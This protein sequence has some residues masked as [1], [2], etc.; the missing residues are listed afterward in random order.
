MIMTDK[1]A[2]QCCKDSSQNLREFMKDNGLSIRKLAKLTGLAPNTIKKFRKDCSGSHFKTFW[3]IGGGM[4]EHPGIMLTI[5]LRD[6][7]QFQS[8]HQ[9]PCP[10]G[11][12]EDVRCPHNN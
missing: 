7:E 3:K 4:A 9:D 5:P 2:R 12:Y 6:I 11:L 8:V 10:F 1:Q